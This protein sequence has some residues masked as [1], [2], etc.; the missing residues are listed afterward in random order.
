VKCWGFNYWGQ[1]GNGG[2]TDL[3]TPTSTGM[4]LA[5]QITA[6]WYSS[7]GLI[8][9]G[10]V[11][12]WGKNVHGQLG[13][14]SNTNQNYPTLTTSF[15]QGLSA[16]SIASGHSASH[17]CAIIIDGSIQCWGPNNFGVIG[18]GT[19]TNRNIPTQV[20]SL[21]NSFAVE[22]GTGYVSTCA[23]FADDSI[24]CWGDNEYGQL[25]DGTTT[26]SLVPVSTLPL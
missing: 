24:M 11:A 26:D 6:N 1:I 5:T 22:V 13:D 15:G 8:P 4:I 18:D 2:N 9:G 17:T 10:Y 25:G 12:C 3:L 23:L 20:S 16:T 7:C 19:T 14:G 21:T